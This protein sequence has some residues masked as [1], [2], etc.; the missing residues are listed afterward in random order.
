MNGNYGLIYLSKSEDKT[1]IP[2]LERLNIID[3]HKVVIFG[4]EM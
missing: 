1:S 4:Q 2:E 3:I